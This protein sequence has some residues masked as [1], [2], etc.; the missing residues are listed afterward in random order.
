[1]PPHW[2]LGSQWRS[3]SMGLWLASRSWC[4]HLSPDPELCLQC[5]VSILGVSPAQ[6]LME[7]SLKSDCLGS[8]PSPPV[9]SHVILG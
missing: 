6:W 1:M 7:W 5:S 8:H 9:T 4:W 2:P 3:S